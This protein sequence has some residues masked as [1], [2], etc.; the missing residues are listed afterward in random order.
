MSQQDGPYK[1]LAVIDAIRKRPG[2]YIGD[3]STP[4]HLATEIVDN[5][6]D[7]IANGHA[8]AGSIQFQDNACWVTDN[9]RGLAVYDMKLSDGTIKDS[10][11]ALCT[12][13]HSG[14]KF[15]N[16][17]YETLIGMHGVGLVVTNALSE[18]L[19]IRARDRNDRANVHVYTFQNAKLTSKE[20]TPEPD[21]GTWSTQVGFKP[22]SLYFETLDFNA[23]SFGERLILTQAK[24]QHSQFAI[25]GKALPKMGFEDLV[26]HYLEINPNNALFNLSHEPSNNQKINVFITYTPS[27]QN[28]I[29]K[30]DV[31][32][33]V[34]TGRFMTT[35]QTAL[36]KVILDKLDK[37]RFKDVPDNLLLLGLK[38]YISMTIPEPRFD[39]Q[40]K[41]RMTLPVKNELIDPLR[42]QIEWFIN[43]EGI[44]DIIHHNIEQR[45][46]K[47]IVKVKTSRNNRVSAGN[48][49]RDCLK[50]PG[51]VIYILEGESALGTLKQCRDTETEAIFPLRGKV[52]N[53]ESNTL[54]AIKGNKEI[55]DFLEAIGPKSSR[56]Y[57]K[58][59][60]VADA[61]PDKSTCPFHQ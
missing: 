12:E 39:S 60:I 11:E 8:S 48:K 29:I 58:I 14:A 40:T 47:S 33:R 35:F 5:M 43:R 6:L 1:A 32:L 49:L 30:G 23:R 15:D 57:E 16:E 59:K 7:E 13:L 4:D 36:K 3:T 50:T 37:K 52:L 51:K 10:I 41:T 56:R 18:W 20:I 21:D 38:L 9:G 42:S 27:D 34:C 28:T 54:D 46:K 31:N 22:S 55:K 24:F 25:N 61:D 53:V 17:D 44:M 2:M 45:L 19:I 26:R